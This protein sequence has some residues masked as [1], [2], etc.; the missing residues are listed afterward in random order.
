MVS[1]QGLRTERVG[2]GWPAVEAAMGSP[3]VEITA[4][5]RRAERG[6]LA[7]RGC[8]EGWVRPHHCTCRRK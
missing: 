3:L 2:G 1:P 7:G 8:A 6:V 5:E 4:L